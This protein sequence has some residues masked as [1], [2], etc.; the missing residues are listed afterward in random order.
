MKEFLRLVYNVKNSIGTG[1]FETVEANDI[2][3]AKIKK[4]YDDHIEKKKII[5]YFD[6]EKEMKEYI[7]L[8]PVT[9]WKLKRK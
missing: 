4:S 5:Q 2:T 6:N 7:N 8:I 9:E 3:E 1:Y